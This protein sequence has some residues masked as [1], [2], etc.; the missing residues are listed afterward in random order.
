MRTFPGVRA[1]PRVSS[2]RC[3]YTLGD[4]VGRQSG[5]W[6]RRKQEGGRTG[7]EGGGVGGVGGLKSGRVGRVTHPCIV[8]VELRRL[9]PQPRIS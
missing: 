7:R 8:V 1:K 2:E 6:W 9:H 5:W 3:L 4:D